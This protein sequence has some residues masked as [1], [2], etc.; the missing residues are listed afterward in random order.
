MIH[1]KFYFNERDGHFYH[2]IDQK[3]V[4]KEEYIKFQ[5]TYTGLIFHEE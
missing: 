2:L 3:A 1:V 5:D 4:S